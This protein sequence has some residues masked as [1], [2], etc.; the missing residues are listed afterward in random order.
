MNRWIVAAIVAASCAA[1]AALAQGVTEKRAQKLSSTAE[2]VYKSARPRLLQV[3][4]ILVNAGR[5]SSIGS[6]FLVSAQ[7]L[8]VTNYHVVSQ[9]AMD[10]ATY[11]LEYI[12]ADG[13][14]GALSLLAFDIANDLAVVQLDRPA[15][16]FFAFDPRVP[17]EMPAKGERLYSMG[18][19][20]DLGFTIV[21]GTYNGTVERSYN[22]RIH[23]SGAINAGMSGGPVV[24]A[25]SGVVGINVAR[26]ID[27]QL[28][29]F[30][31]P[32]RFA[33]DLVTRAAGGAPLDADAIRG[34]VGRQLVA[35]QAGLYKALGAETWR[36]AAF[37]PYR[38]PESPAARFNCWASTNANDVPK[39][40]GTVN[41]TSCSTSTWLYVA[42]DLTTGQIRATQQYLKSVDLNDF[43]FASFLSNYF[44]PA[45]L[46]WS[47]KRHTR[48]RCH[49]SF[50]E[51]DGERPAMRAVWCARA[52]RDY[53]GLYDVSLVAV[54]QDASREALV[55]RLSMQGVA[56]DSAVELGRRFLGEV[57][58]AR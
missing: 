11:R 57:R 28:V 4:T 25:A 12:A 16:G 45:S 38:A 20:L 24:S 40:R 33:A 21:E 13:E 50:V 51:A 7:G 49:D 46:G 6:G 56:Y 3:R 43:Q 30:L 18:N 27:G 36:S 5:Q 54:T 52:Y 58:R 29:S 35:W 23:F 48:S 31:V 37:G 1:P 2:R 19:P 47:R 8:A 32:A 34:E 55:T 39:P 22:E 15:P 42:N 10:P 14:K 9:F 17:R 44:Q 53:A 41:T 26:R